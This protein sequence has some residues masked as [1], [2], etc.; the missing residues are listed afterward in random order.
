MGS[1]DQIMA[2]ARAMV[3]QWLHGPCQEMTTS[4]SAGGATPEWN[5]FITSESTDDDGQ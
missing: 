5:T 3:S 1:W 4:T 2:E